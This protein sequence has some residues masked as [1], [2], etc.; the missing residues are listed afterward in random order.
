[1]TNISDYRQDTPHT[2]RPLFTML[3]L[4]SRS[5]VKDFEAVFLNKREKIGDNKKLKNEKILFRIGFDR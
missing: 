5:A 2:A 3:G 1:M 4:K